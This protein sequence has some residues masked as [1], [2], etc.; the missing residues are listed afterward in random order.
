MA[1]NRRRDDGWLLIAI[2][3][4]DNV[5]CVFCV[6]QREIWYSLYGMVLVVVVCVSHD[7]IQGMMSAPLMDAP[8]KLFREEFV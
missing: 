7:L 4:P 5:F 2:V 3:S 8:A 6:K 1:V